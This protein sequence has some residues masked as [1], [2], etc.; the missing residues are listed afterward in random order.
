[1]W[2]GSISADLRCF[3][4]I[5]GI[6]LSIKICKANGAEGKTT[7]YHI[8]CTG[9]MRNNEEFCLKLQQIENNE[10]CELYGDMTSLVHCHQV[11]QNGNTLLLV[12]SFC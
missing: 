7:I 6:F 2:T 3:T 12:Q 10:S 4:I 8:D 5:G 11:N 9:N 1:M